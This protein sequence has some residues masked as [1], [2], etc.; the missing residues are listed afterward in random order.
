MLS[1]TFADANPLE[2]GNIERAES[3]DIGVLEDSLVD[4]TAKVGSVDDVLK[5]LDSASEDP[6]EIR[7]MVLE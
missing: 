1:D 3:N 2:E 7:L 5:K 4:G 6:V